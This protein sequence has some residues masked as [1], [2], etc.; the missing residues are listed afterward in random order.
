M[1]Y[2]DHEIPWIDIISHIAFSI[3]DLVIAVPTLV[4]YNQIAYK[5]QQSLSAEI[6]WFYS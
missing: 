4:V 1:R 5:V 6:I 2:R 3:Y